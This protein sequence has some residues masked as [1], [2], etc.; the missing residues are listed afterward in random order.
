MDTVQ[1]PVCNKLGIMTV[2]FQYDSD[3]RLHNIC[4]FSDAK[5]EKKTEG[6]NGVFCERFTYD[7]CGNLIE[8]SQL[9]RSEISRYDNNGVSTYQYVYSD[10]RLSGETFLGIIGSPVCDKR[11]KSYSLEFEGKKVEGDRNITIFINSSDTKETSGTENP[12]A[13]KNADK[14]SGM[15]QGQSDKSQKAEN[16]GMTEEESVFG[17]K[18][19]SGEG[20]V[21]EIQD[22]IEER[23]KSKKYSAVRYR[24]QK[25][26]A[27]IELCYL[28]SRGESGK[29]RGRLCF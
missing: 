15:Q 29:K 23:E 20:K 7:S 10:G 11:F 5:K 14:N 2:S 13:I 3:E 6:F 21:N 8:R 22:N 4:Y 17:M 25:N 1:K 9:D 28:D 18:K 24:I 27:V 26:D 16:S 12:A 19:D